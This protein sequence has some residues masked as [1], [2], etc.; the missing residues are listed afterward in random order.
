[1]NLLD[2]KTWALL[3]EGRTKGVFQLESNLGKSWAKKVSPSSIE[4]LSALIAII[5]PGSLHA[6]MDGKSLSQHFVDR[7]N[8]KDTTVYLH[9][10][11]EPILKNTYGVLVYQE[12]AMRIAQDLAGFDLIEA[13]DLRKAIGKKKADLM[14]KIKVKFLDGCEKNKVVTRDE[15]DE[16][17]GWIEKSA[18]YSFNKSHSVSYAFN[19]F[20][21][22]YYK[23]NHPIEFFVSYLRHSKDSPKPHQEVYELVADAKMHGINCSMCR[24]NNWV[25]DYSRSGDNI[26]FGVKS[27]KGMGNI[28]GDKTCR[29][30]VDGSAE[31][32]KPPGKLT[33]LEILLFVSSKCTK[34]GFDPLCSVGFFT[35]KETGVNRNTA[36]FQYDTFRVLNKN[37]LAW[38][39]EQYPKRKWKT[40]K[41]C[42]VDLAPTKKEGGGTNTVSRENKIKNEIHFLDNPPYELVDDPQWVIESEI[43]LLG[44]PISMSKLETSETVFT[45]NSS[46]K[47]IVD[48]KFG[49]N[50]SVAGNVYRVNHHK[51]KKGKSAGELM[52]FLTIEDETGTLDSVIVFPKVREQYSWLLY[53]GNNL[54]FH[55]E[56]K[57]GEGSLLVDKIHEI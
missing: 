27:V 41:D 13:D 1:M 38:A 51:T 35:T 14:A 48:G 19:S 56:V 34:S 12:Q 37:E 39:I 30:I 53:E 23:A 55:G 44:C 25:E 17:F 33:W 43:A 11:L 40:L 9:P 21:S 7:K 36:Q 4:E 47:E 45:S 24:I 18:R 5:R 46:C 31:L 52:S 57:R 26:L 6:M 16:I 54:L 3:Q 20:T 15:G 28:Y 2:D 22:A 10:S 50:I 8:G 42:L 49:S 29:A 32:G